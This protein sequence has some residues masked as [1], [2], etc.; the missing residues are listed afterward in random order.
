MTCALQH[1]EVRG[2]GRCDEPH[3]HE[4][5]HETAESADFLHETVDTEACRK[6]QADPRD[7]TVGHS[8]NE[9]SGE[10]GKQRDN[11]DS[12][13]SLA[14]KHHTQ[15]NTD[16]RID[17]VAKTCLHE[18]LRGNR[19]QVNEPVS[20]EHETC[21]QR[22]CYRG[23]VPEGGAEV[24]AVEDHDDWCEQHR[25]PENA[26]SKKLEGRNIVQPTPVDR[27]KT[28]HEVSQ[29]RRERSNSLRLIIRRHFVSI[30]IRLA[31]AS[32]DDSGAA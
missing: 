12:G 3:L 28:P 7:P 6:C 23:T 29:E 32:T 22:D 14:K 20:G 16:E 21:D 9:H 17:V 1:D 2:S 11:L 10:R 4:Q 27:Q 13:Q 8:E 19:P 26:M 15:E 5:S 24:P 18:P 30:V 25:R 31:E